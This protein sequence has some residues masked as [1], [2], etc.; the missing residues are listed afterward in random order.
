VRV[1][2]KTQDTFLS[3][4]FGVA[5]WALFACLTAALLFSFVNERLLAQE[6]WTEAGRRRLLGYATG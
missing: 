4:F 3:S 6:I 5:G 1:P 2:V